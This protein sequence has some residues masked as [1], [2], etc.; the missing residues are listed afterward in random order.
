MARVVCLGIVVL[1]RVWE[2]PAIPSEPLKVIATNWRE[3]GGGMAATAAAAVAV[4]GGE[5]SYWGRVGDD[6]TGAWLREEL[7]QRGVDVAAMRGFAG[8]DTAQ[9]AILV[10]PQGERLLAVF[11]GRN[12][13]LD[14]GWLPLDALDDATAVM[15]D[16]RWREGASAL[17]EA[18]GR[19]RIPRVLDADIAEK[20]TLAQLA[21]GADYVVFSTSGLAALTGNER[22]AEGLRLAAAQLTAQVGVTLGAEGYLWLAAGELCHEPGFA[23]T[24]RDTNGAGDV[25]H[26]A[27]ALAIAEGKTIRE[28]ARFANAAAA[29]KC[30]AGQGWDGIPGRTAVDLLVR[31]RSLPL[32]P[33]GKQ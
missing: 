24:A 4:L 5:A 16:M 32:T 13:S 25:F 30:Q 2:V 3:S 20:E 8:A 33:E 10:D 18:A 23:V 1:D 21:A 11:P 17:L 9:S 7:T 12:L 22:P 31:S 14:P 27:Y 6:A 29:L 26:G 28:A 15:V 19:R